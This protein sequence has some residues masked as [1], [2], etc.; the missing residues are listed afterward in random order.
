V[1]NLN[2]S[3]KQSTVNQNLTKSGGA[4]IGY[5]DIAVRTLVHNLGKTRTMAARRQIVREFLYYSDKYFDN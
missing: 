2:M 3:R 1:G 5:L 4:V